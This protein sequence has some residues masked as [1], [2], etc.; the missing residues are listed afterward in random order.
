MIWN[1]GCINKH[2]WTG[3]I[4]SVQKKIKRITWAR[5]RYLRRPQGEH[6]CVILLQRAG[7]VVVRG[8]CVK[9]NCMV[10]QLNA[11][12]R[13]PGFKSGLLCY[14]DVQ[15]QDWLFQLFCVSYAPNQEKEQCKELLWILQI[16]ASKAFG[17]LSERLEY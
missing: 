2:W 8:F 7:L 16:S 14:L 11:G 3:T 15:Y 5:F 1:L 10:K 13:L 12:A 9:R 4:Q 6:T 17:T